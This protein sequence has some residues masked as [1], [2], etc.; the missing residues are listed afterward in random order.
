M[1]EL[2]RLSQEHFDLQTSLCAGDGPR[3]R[4]LFSRDGTPYG[5]AMELPLH[6]C[7]CLPVDPLTTPSVISTENLRRFQQAHGALPEQLEDFLWSAERW[8]IRLTAFLLWMARTARKPDVV[9]DRSPESTALWQAYTASLPSGEELACLLMFAPSDRYELQSMSLER[10]ASRQRD[11][12]FGLHHAFF[13]AT[14]GELGALKLAR[15]PADTL[16]ALGCVRSRTFADDPENGGG[17]SLVLLAPVADL[18]NHDTDYNATFEVDDAAGVFRLWANM[19]MEAGTEFCISYGEDKSSDE[20]MRDYGFSLS[21]NPND[22]LD[23][24]RRLSCAQPPEGV[25]LDEDPHWS[26]PPQ[27]RRELLALDLPTLERARDVVVSRRGRKAAQIDP[28]VDAR[29]WHSVF[30][31]LPLMRDVGPGG[32]KPEKQREFDSAGILEDMVR[33]RQ[34]EMLLSAAQDRELL[35]SG[36]LSPRMAAAVAARAERKV[37]IEMTIEVLRSYRTVIRKRPE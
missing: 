32:V 31:S 34:S 2:F 27:M 23:V 11:W 7:L 17:E 10:E 3:G 9:P 13:D 8:D 22:R 1:D 33:A 14:R 4:G 21:G 15:T 20:L 36:G 26:R 30:E 35:S 12:A 28:T 5:A 24:P 29:R 25:D 37:L 6:H 18:A 19:D 16:W